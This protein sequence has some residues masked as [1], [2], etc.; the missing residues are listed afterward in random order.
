MKGKKARV[1]SILLI[2]IF[3]QSSVLGVLPAKAAFAA[4]TGITVNVTDSSNQ[5]I[6]SY[7]N[8]G[9]VSSNK[10]LS[11]T[12]PVRLAAD[13]KAKISYNLTNVT[14]SKYKFVA[15]NNLTTLPAFPSDSAMTNI[16]MTESNTY[17]AYKDDIGVQN[18]LTTRLYDY[19]GKAGTANLTRDV[20]FGSPAFDVFTQKASSDSS[21]S[22]RFYN[23]YMN[24]YVTTNYDIGS[25]DGSNFYIGKRGDSS[26]ACTKVYSN[27]VS[28]AN[29]NTVNY[30]N[31][32]YPKTKNAAWKALKVWGYFVPQTTGNYNLGAWSDDGAYG[33][34]I[35]DKEKKEFVNDWS[36][37]APK[38]KYNTAAIHLIG[39]DSGTPHYYPIYMEWYEGCPTQSSFVPEYKFNNGN[40]KAIPASELYSSKTTTP[41]DI[42]EA[43]FGDVSGISFPAQDGIYYIATKFKSSEGSGTT[44]GLYGPF[45]VDN[46]APVI[47]NLRVISNNTNNNK[48]AVAGNTLTVTFTAS[49]NLGGNP[50]ILVNGFPTNGT[51]TKDA[52]NNYT[53]TV[54]IGS[55]SSVNTQKDK[56]V[57]G[58]I[59]LQIAHYS[60]LSNN[61]GSTTED[62]TV[63]YDITQPL[64]TISYSQNPAS[65]GT[66]VIT[67]TF[68]EPINSNDIEKISI[69]PA[70]SLNIDTANMTPSSDRKTWTYNY[71]VNADNG[72]TYKDGQAK[73]SLSSVHDAA[74]NISI[75]PTTNTTFIINTTKPTVSLTFSAN[76]TSKG[77]ELITATYSK[78]VG[79]AFTPQIAINQAGTNDLALTN[80]TQVG[81]N[82]TTWTYTYT[83]CENGTTTNGKTNVDGDAIVTLSPVEDT[84]GNKVAAPAV[85]KFVIDTIAPTFTITYTKDPVNAGIQ[86]IT[87]TY[88]DAS[89]I[90]S[91]ETPSISIAQPGNAL[92][93]YDVTDV[94]MTPYGLSGKVWTYNY[95]VKADNGKTNK[96]GQATVTLSSIKDAAGNA[97][98][99]ED[100]HFTIDT[101]APTIDISA[102]SSDL[103]KNTS[104]T[105][106]VTYTG[107]NTVTLNS[108]NVSLVKTGTADGTVTESGTGNTRTVTVSNIT[109]DG[110]LAIKIA[111]GTASDTAGNFA[112]TA[113]SGAFTVDNEAKAP[114]I[115]D[116]VMTDNIINKAEQDN[117]TI[118]GSGEAGATATIKITDGVKTITKTANVSGNYPGSGDYSVIGIDVSGL[119]DG[120]LDISVTQKDGLGNVSA[121]TTKTVEKDTAAPTI[122]VPSYSED[123]NKHITVAPT[124]DGATVV[125]A[126]HVFTANGSYN[127]TA[128]DPAGNS[129]MLTVTIDTIVPVIVAPSVSSLVVRQKSTKIITV[130]LPKLGQKGSKTNPSMYEKDSGLVVGDIKVRIKKG[131]QYIYTPTI[132]NGKLTVKAKNSTTKVG[133]VE[134]EVYCECDGVSI[135][136]TKI[137]VQILPYGKN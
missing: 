56:L 75:A 73:V 129:T 59:K 95:T 48:L 10:I 109:G 27:P 130:T 23:T 43:Y 96:D 3:I 51:I 58:T 63:T 110:K 41:G 29:S 115:D 117:V 54:S 84:V 79:N 12:N 21:N 47:N 16:D 50:Q 98:I 14:F 77:S 35:V 39:A 104:V 85:N 38:D 37:A 61:A 114:T 64:A 5:N 2:A 78:S 62:A 128:T 26:D 46:T 105:Y 133:V 126:S 123:T 24:T 132:K 134:I 32:Y 4:T 65:V 11:S 124:S 34:L 101:K 107:A 67:A 76:P 55:D 82:R 13:A 93:S 53:A 102:P 122:T 60:D 40:F 81:D 45:I 131:A 137:P 112:L 28:T 68:P 7:T 89:T 116:P 97:S 71:T 103:T 113:T 18:Y 70:G 31:S 20:S 22:N 30:N 136:N 111:A 90:K 94:A 25:T 91:G 49:E 87:A 1:F 57:D 44:S 125:P 106:T 80:M 99:Q 19:K 6:T 120:N 36:I 42:A 135:Q 33:Y 15:A 121:A 100:K 92:G 9:G 88:V 83:V 8:G 108:S 66:E 119:E 127:F 118:S 86:V 72:T 17:E 69:D 52:Q 74:G